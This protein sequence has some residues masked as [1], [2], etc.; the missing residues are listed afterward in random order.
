VTFGPVGT[1]P[2]TPPP[3]PPITP[4]S[5]PS[6]PPSGSASGHVVPGIVQRCWLHSALEPKPS[7]AKQSLSALQ[8]TSQSACAAS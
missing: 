6:M 7:S 4:P 1:K 2:S 3:S 8:L 5:L